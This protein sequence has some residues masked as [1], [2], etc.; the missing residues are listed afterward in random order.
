MDGVHEMF[1][2]KYMDEQMQQA[3]GGKADFDGAAEYGQE[4]LARMAKV[5][6]GKFGQASEEEMAKRRADDLVEAQQRVHD[7]L[8]QWVKFFAGN[9][10]YE[11]VGRV[12]RD[13]EKPK[14]PAL[15]EEALK[16]RP[17]KGGLLDDVM[18]NG[19]FG[20]MPLGGKGSPKGKPSR[21]EL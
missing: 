4:E 17:L 5:M 11:V 8:A 6:M 7:Q 12:I 15:C 14:P 13:K 9:E 18:K 1:M 3:A 10:K 20:G 19:K 16:K 2:P 21:E